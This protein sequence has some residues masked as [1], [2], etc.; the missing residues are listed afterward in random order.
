MTESCNLYTKEAAGLI[1]KE[2][3]KLRKDPSNTSYGDEVLQDLAAV[4]VVA[5][6]LEELKQK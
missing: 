5:K 1:L 2:Y 4:I 6:L 3:W